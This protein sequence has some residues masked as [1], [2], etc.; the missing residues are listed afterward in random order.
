MKWSCDSHLANQMSWVFVYV[1]NF[2][3][4]TSCFIPLGNLGVDLFNAGDPPGSRQ[5]YDKLT[6]RS[7]QKIAAGHDSRMSREV[8]SDADAV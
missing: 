6:T 3:T 4:K 1:N 5:A 8:G 7:R 2:L